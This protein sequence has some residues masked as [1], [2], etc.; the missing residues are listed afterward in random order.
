[1][2]FTVLMFQRF[3]VW[4]RLG[5]IALPPPQIQHALRL[6]EAAERLA[7]DAAARAHGSLSDIYRQLAA[8]DTLRRTHQRR[9]RA[10]RALAIKET[11]LHAA[12][13]AQAD[14]AR[15][16]ADQRAEH[17]EA[18]EAAAKLLV[19]GLAQ[20]RR[21]FTEEL[22]RFRV[23]GDELRLDVAADLA[24][25]FRVAHGAA[26]LE[27]HYLRERRAV[28]QSRVRA[29]E[30]EFEA[31]ASMGD[32]AAATRL[33]DATRGRKAELRK[34]EDRLEALEQDMRR[35]EGLADAPWALLRRS[36]LGG[37]AAADAEAVRVRT[38]AANLEAWGGDERSVE[39]PEAWNRAMSEEADRVKASRLIT[40]A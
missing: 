18:A 11:A 23:V 6:S 35:M 12:F 15:R 40:A 16:A 2:C 32:E 39:R 9:Q 5:L 29:S 30:A 31:S 33:R 26:H 1:M 36:A 3:T 34:V 4:M 37:P 14:T 20:A 27:A 24:A 21:L 7:A 19:E 25:A 17:A 38:S 28:E 13:V 22:E 10:L 8:A